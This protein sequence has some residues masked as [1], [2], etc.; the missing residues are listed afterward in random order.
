MKIQVK[1]PY[2]SF[3]SARPNRGVNP[4]YLIKMLDEGLSGRSSLM[5]SIS[6]PVNEISG[7]LS[8]LYEEVPLG[9]GGKRSIE[10]KVSRLQKEYDDLVKG[11]VGKM[12]SPEAIQKNK[13]I[14]AA[15]SPGS[16][17]SDVE[18]Y[19]TNLKDFESDTS[20]KT[21]GQLYVRNGS[22]GVRNPV[23][24]SVSLINIADLSGLSDEEK[25]YVRRN[26]LTNREAFE[27]H[28]SSDPV[29]SGLY[30]DFSSTARVEDTMKDIASM[31]DKV[32]KR[33]TVED[34]IVSLG[35]LLGDQSLASIIVKGTFTV[36]GN[37]EGLEIIRDKLMSGGFVSQAQ[38]DAIY[39]HYAQQLLNRGEDVTEE[40]I[41]ESFLGDLTDMANSKVDSYVSDKFVK[42][43]DVLNRG[44]REL[45][46]YTLA[47][48]GVGDKEIYLNAPWDSNTTINTVMTRY[49]NINI[50]A[51]DNRRITLGESPD[52]SS[53][54]DLKNARLASN[55]S[56]PEGTVRNMAITEN[57]NYTGWFFT[58]P[59]GS[60]VIDPI[61]EKAK[62]GDE[63]FVDLYERFT[64]L[65]PEVSSQARREYDTILKELSDNYGMRQYTMVTGYIL[66]N[67]DN[68]A[69]IEENP[70]YFEEEKD[71]QLLRDIYPTWGLDPEG[72]T[73]WFGLVGPTPVYKTAIFIPN[74]SSIHTESNYTRRMKLR[75]AVE[76]QTDPQQYGS[77]YKNGGVF[78]EGPNKL[79]KFGGGGKLGK[80]KFLSIEDLRR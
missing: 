76:T 8:K 52:I 70:K 48:Q 20:R 27:A 9:E 41:M 72:D 3:T 13:E 35:E 78:L 1:N 77:R 50:R 58:N 19:K 22:I 16:Y 37:Q 18:R 53:W 38:M 10:N 69:I 14:I 17:A 29:G 32:G 57:E 68:E 80:I 33:E 64:S 67:D 63:Y 54:G 34:K 73:S 71:Q 11:D 75:E 31:M 51:N 62:E 5:G 24:N 45:S 79:G 56:I 55:A 7:M 28:M 43:D 26:M 61:K 60:I 30:T 65:D 12:F 39:G 4:E 25:A 2:M 15:L 21:A 23:D 47:Q 36:R 40:N 44:D 66:G 74:F 59:D 49:P 6:T 46:R 42:A